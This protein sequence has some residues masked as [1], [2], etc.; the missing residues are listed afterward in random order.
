MLACVLSVVCAMTPVATAQPLGIGT[1][2]VFRITLLPEG[3]TG[4]A[5]NQAGHVVGSGIG[6]VRIWTGGNSIRLVQAAASGYSDA[7]GINSRDDVAGSS[8]YGTGSIAFANIGGVVHRIADANPDTQPS[9]AFGINDANWVVG[10][11]YDWR[12]G[13]ES[14]AFIYRNGNLL[15]L[16]TLGGNSSVGLA[17]SNRGHVTGDSILPGTGQGQAARNAFLYLNGRMAGLGALPGDDVSTGRDVNDRG[18]VVGTSARSGQAAS[19]GFLFSNGRMVD[20]GK[21]GNGLLTE[22]RAINN[23]GAVVGQ[24]FLTSP[25]DDPRGFIYVRGRIVDLN[26]LVDRA[27]GWVITAAIDIND[28]F[29]VLGQACRSDGT[30]CRMARLEPRVPVGRGGLPG[31]LQGEGRDWPDA[32]ER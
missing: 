31:I 17:I 10:T 5:M 9:F 29:Q 19:R 3:M 32:L 13:N 30:M 28:A 18:E 25:A 4:G 23:A 11:V 7:S 1:V 15:L 6:G 26:R 8:S 24:S 27:Q 14:R 16:P 20:V 22:A 21:L 12:N 2:P